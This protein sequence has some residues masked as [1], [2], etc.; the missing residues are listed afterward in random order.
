MA[1]RA[2]MRL[3]SWLAAGG[4]I[5]AAEADEQQQQQLDLTC[6]G[7]SLYQ[8]RTNLVTQAAFAAQSSSSVSVPLQRRAVATA[9]DSAATASGV[10]RSKAGKKMAYFGELTVGEPAQKFTV[11]FDTGSGNLIVPG[12]QCTAAACESHAQFD[13]ALSPDSKRVMCDGELAEDGLEPDEITITFGTG[14]VSGQCM[15]DAICI[16]SA[17]T[18]GMFIASVDES[19]QPFAF[20]GFDGILGLALESMA[21]SY[22]FSIMNKLRDEQKLK[23]PLFSV[24]M[25]D[26]DDETSEITFGDIKSEHMDSEVFWVDVTGETGFW[27]VKIADITFDDERQ[28][29][30]EDCKVAVDTGTSQLAGPSSLIAEMRQKLDFS[31]DCT[32]IASLPRLGFVIGNRTLNLMPSDYIDR[33][34]HD[35]G[36]EFCDIALMSLD[37]P[38]PK[39]PLFIFGI[40]FLQKFFTVYDLEN[41]RVGFAAAK[42]KVPTPGLIG[43]VAERHPA[44]AAVNAS[45]ATLSAARKHGTPQQK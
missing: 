9:A 41:K 39:G 40:P 11:V 10:S 3:S 31:S 16:G 33:E 1:H 30:C 8:V 23:Q 22:D 37:V 43:I 28:G 24:F 18:Q 25:S 4:V 45:A 36:N 42:H 15:Q 21:Q 34:I 12:K 44:A 29:L 7:P 2:L 13:S 5:L 32:N 6:A 20:F 35:N 17:C 19:S 14:H 26:S 38:P 27:E